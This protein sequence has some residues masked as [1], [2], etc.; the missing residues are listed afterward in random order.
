[1]VGCTSLVFRDRPG[2]KVSLGTIKVPM[3]C[4]GGGSLV[5][6]P[7]KRGRIRRRGQRMEPRESTKSTDRGSKKEPRKDAEEEK[8]GRQEE[9]QDRVSER[10][11]QLCQMPIG[12]GSLGVAP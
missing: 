4:G 3:A 9:S 2:S 5:G 10:S 11:Q 1:M 8:P 6:S 7:R 12:Q